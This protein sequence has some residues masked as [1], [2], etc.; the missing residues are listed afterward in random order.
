VVGLLAFTRLAPNGFSEQHL[1]IARQ[2]A[3]LVAPLIENT[4]F[5]ERER[6]RGR[7]LAG[8][9]ELAPIFGTTLN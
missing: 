6:G 4:I 1:A 2:V 8:L 7:R 5:L 3:A 9:T